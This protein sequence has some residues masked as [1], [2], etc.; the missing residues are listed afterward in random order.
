[1]NFFPSRE[2]IA[3]THNRMVHTRLKSAICRAGCVTFSA[4]RRQHRPVDMDR[5]PTRQRLAPLLK[6]H[7][8]DPQKSSH[9]ERL[10]DASQLIFQT[11]ITD[12]QC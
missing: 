10:Q 1:M 9:I 7:H 12:A 11:S 2:I 5:N 6:M 4:E 8:E 3:N